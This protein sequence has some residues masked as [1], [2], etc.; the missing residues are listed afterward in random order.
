MDYHTIRG[1]FTSDKFLGDTDITS[2]LD[3]PKLSAQIHVNVYRGV[4]EVHSRLIPF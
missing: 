1:D 2:D 4:S 3:V